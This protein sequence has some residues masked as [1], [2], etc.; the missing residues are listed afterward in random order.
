MAVNAEMRRMH[1]Q[2]EEETIPS[3]AVHDIL[4]RRVELRKR[5]SNS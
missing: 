1:Q 4:L 5:G 3:R 2:W